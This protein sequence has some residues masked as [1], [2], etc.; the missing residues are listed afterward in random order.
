MC[1]NDAIMSEIA[2]EAVIEIYGRMFRWV[3]PLFVCIWTVRPETREQVYNYCPNS[4]QA[5]EHE[6]PKKLSL[7]KF[8]QDGAEQVAS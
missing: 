3:N 1:D 7:L 4:R 6:K 8:G 2:R 5:K